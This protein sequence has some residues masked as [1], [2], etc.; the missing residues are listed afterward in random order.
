MW[1]KVVSG[2]WPERAEGGRMR[3]EGRGER[4]E[5]RV[6]KIPPSAFRPLLIPNP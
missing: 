4:G 2:Q 6:K 1:E 5:G 3:G